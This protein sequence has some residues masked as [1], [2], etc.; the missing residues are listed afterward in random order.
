MQTRL[1]R[2]YCDEAELLPLLISHG[3]IRRVR[4]IQIVIKPLGGDS[5]KVTL[6]ASK[7]TVGEAKA[8]VAR[9]QGTAEDCQELYRVAERADGLAVREDD[10]EPEPLEDESMLLKEGDVVAMAVKVN[11]VRSATLPLIRNLL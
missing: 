3:L 10:A 11:S 4:T 6:D 2:K 9:S 8:E 5:F 1:G 7:P